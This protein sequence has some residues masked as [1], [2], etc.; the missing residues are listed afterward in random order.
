MSGKVGRDRI[1]IDRFFAGPGARADRWYRL[2]KLA[3]AALAELTATRCQQPTR[4]T[5]SSDPR[6][7]HIV[8]PHPHAHWR[9]R[10]DEL[11]GIMLNA[12]KKAPDGRGIR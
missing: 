4:R 2:V 7:T 3:E 8:R 1:Q 9:D 10:P 12:H 11:S 5:R 6:H